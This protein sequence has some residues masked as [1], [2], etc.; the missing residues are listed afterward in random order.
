MNLKTVQQIT[1]IKKLLESEFT[2][3]DFDTLVHVSIARAISLELP[4]PTNE[5]ASVEVHFQ[6][7]IAMTAGD[8]ISK[9]NEDYILDVNRMM[10][11]I[12]QFYMLRY[13]LVFSPK[14]FSKALSMIAATSPDTLPGEVVENLA[15]YNTEGVNSA[16]DCL[17]WALREDFV[18]AVPAEPVISATANVV[19]G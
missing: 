8:I 14:D 5:V 15:R 4:L 17:V 1:N 10:S 3:A 13:R 16:F 9:I 11:L 7:A 18:E 6:N 2:G 19:E 12:R